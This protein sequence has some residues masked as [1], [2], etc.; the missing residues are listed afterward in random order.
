MQTHIGLVLSAAAF[1]LA[2]CAGP[3]AHRLK[4]QWPDAPETFLIN[5]VPF[6][7]QTAYQCGPA[8]LATVL[9]YRGHAVSPDALK[10]ILY[11]PDKKGSLQI[12][13]TAAARRYGM[14]AY[15]IAGSLNDLIHE[16]S[17]GNP[18]LVMQNLGLDWLPRWHFAVVVGY[19]KNKRTFILRSGTNHSR[20]TAFSAFENTWRRA[21]N[22]GLV[23]VSPAQPP[24]AT[25]HMHSYLKAAHTLEKTGQIAAAQTAYETATKTW[26]GTPLTWL[27]LG[28]SHY[29][30][31][32]FQ[33]AES[34]YRQA[35]AADARSD[36]AWNNLANAF[37]RQ[38]CY[39]PAVQ[40][41]QCAIALAP[42]NRQYRQTLTKLT[43]PPEAALSCMPPP[44]C[45]A[46]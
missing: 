18:V 34:A 19:D 32:A 41:A 38:G 29:Q 14:L 36:P 20:R 21:Q 45:P 40:A 28:N 24:P 39:E 8:A 42:G 25:A 12:E 44:T 43:M 16:V 17:A 35:I 23:I 9:D 1:L 11:I 37:A 27:I 46:Y 7:P 33:D 5:D 13:I 10:N 31:T 30:N 4:T 6:F 26:A 22:W 3:Q 2:S 15:P